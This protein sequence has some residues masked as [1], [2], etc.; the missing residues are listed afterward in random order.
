MADKSMAHVSM[1]MVKA[2]ED[3]ATHPSAFDKFVL[4]NSKSWSGQVRNW[5]VGL[6]RYSTMSEELQQTAE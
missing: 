3:A 6:L 4:N 1:A 5:T 2:V